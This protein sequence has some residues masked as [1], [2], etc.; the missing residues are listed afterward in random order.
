MS[1]INHEQGYVAYGYDDFFSKY[2]P[3][4]IETSAMVDVVGTAAIAW[5]HDGIEVEANR[6]VEIYYV[7]ADTK[8][9]NEPDMVLT[10]GK[11][12]PYNA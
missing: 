7:T 9:E 10:T 12:M 5:L 3:I 1:W 2:K 11:E 6:R 8:L 4:W